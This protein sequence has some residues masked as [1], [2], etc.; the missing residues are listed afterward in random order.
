MPWESLSSTI[1]LR[2]NYI[3]RTCPRLPCTVLF[4]KDEWQSVDLHRLVVFQKTPLKY[5]SLMVL[6]VEPLAKV[7]SFSSMRVL[8]QLVCPVKV[9][10]QVPLRSQNLMVLS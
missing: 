3:G 8:T 6:S 10:R 1:N 2:R 9:F 7:P 4:D 5:H